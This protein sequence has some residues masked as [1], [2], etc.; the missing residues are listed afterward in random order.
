M[1]KYRVEFSTNEYI[2][3]NAYGI[4][5]AYFE[6]ITYENHNRFIEDIEKVSG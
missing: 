4:A 3:V 2:Y 6:A 5:D 1:K